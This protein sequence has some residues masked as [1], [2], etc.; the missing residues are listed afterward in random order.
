MIGKDS[1]QNVERTADKPNPST[2]L[3]A[4]HRQK[5]VLE[6]NSISSSSP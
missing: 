3:G 5:Q 4:K 2:L 6:M 1:P